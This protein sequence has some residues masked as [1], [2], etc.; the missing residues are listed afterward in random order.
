M[1][2]PPTIQIASSYSN[3]GGLLGKSG[4]DPMITVA[5]IPSWRPA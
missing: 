4:S 1:P 3:R 2:K 5:A